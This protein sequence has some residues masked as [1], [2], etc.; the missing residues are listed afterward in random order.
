MRV[1]ELLS[2]YDSEM[3]RD[4][5]AERGMTLE[6]VGPLVRVMGEQCCVIYS[7]L[8]EFTAPD[9]IREQ[10]IFFRSA[11]KEVEWKVYGHDRPS[12]LSELLQAEG[13]VPDPIETLVIYDL[14]K[15]LER[16]FVPEDLEIRRITERSEFEK[17][18]EASETAFGPEEGWHLG[19]Y[20]ERLTDPS[21]AAYVAYLH[22]EPVG[23]ARLEMPPAR[24][25]ASLWGGGTLPQYR[26]QGIYRALV[27]VR[28]NL[29]ASHGYRF[30]TVDARETSRPILERLGFVAVDS[31]R[32]W[33]LKPV[34]NASRPIP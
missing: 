6:S 17:A 7:S 32:G 11:G 28:A 8:D 24:S 13:L 9:A 4:P 10:V 14:A 1:D 21:F 18:I 26:R 12:N 19:E 23:S 5:P 27:S 22:G 30:L 34:G 15:P 29:A 3:R 33:I 25:F 31:I 2:L 20:P 16:G